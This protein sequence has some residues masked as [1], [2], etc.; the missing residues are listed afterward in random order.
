MSD[1][2]LRMEERRSAFGG[3]GW[4]RREVL[5]ADPPHRLPA[6]TRLPPAPCPAAEKE[7]PVHAACGRHWLLQPPAKADGLR[8]SGWRG[9][10]QEVAV[11]DGV[12]PGGCSSSASSGSSPCGGGS[13]DTVSEG[14][15]GGRTVGVLRLQRR[16]RWQSLLRRRDRQLPWQR[17]R[18][19]RR[20]RR[21]R[22][23][24]Q[25]TPCCPPRC[26]SSSRM[27]A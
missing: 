6:H 18:R 4:G 7:V 17:H 13:I 25:T 15:G 21:A 26:S 1:V 12:A 22:L 9:G 23:A 19:H 11:W 16:Q 3:V 8:H 27:T 10:V 14:C 24:M 20:Q 2:Q 5:K